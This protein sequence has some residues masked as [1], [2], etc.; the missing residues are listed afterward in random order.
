MF[1]DLEV[2]SLIEVVS[3]NRWHP[4]EIFRQVAGRIRRYRYEGMAAG[5]RVFLHFGNRLEFFADLLAIWKLGAVAIPVDGR[6]TAFEVL[7]LAR[8]ADPR[9]SIIDEKTDPSTIEGV[10][11]GSVRV[12]NTLDV[13]TD[14]GAVPDSNFVESPA[15][16]EDDALILFTSGSTGTPKGVVHTHGSLR[17]RWLALRESLG[18][19]SYRRTLCL[20]PTHFGH[21]LICNCLFP[22]LF[23][24]DLFIA[25]PYHPELIMRLGSLIDE[26]KIT[27]L[28]SVPSLWQLALKTSRS[29]KAQTLERVHCG[30]APLSAHLWQE[31]QSWAS[32]KAVFNAYG[33]TETASWVAGT[34]LAD[35]TPM[36]GLVGKPW[37]AVIKILKTC[38]TSTL[39]D[40]GMECAPGKSGYV[41]INTPALM[42]GY[43]NQ[44]HL[45]GQVIRKGWFLTGDIGVFDE[46]GVFF[47]KGREREEI[48]KSGIKIYPADIDA[49][50]EQFE[51]TVDVCTFGFDDQLCGQNVGMAVVLK[52][53]ETTTIRE[54]YWWM[55]SHLAEFK[56][57]VRWYLMDSI[58]RS[59]RGKTNRSAVMKQCAG[60]PPVDLQNV[61]RDLRE[62]PL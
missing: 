36:D 7:T 37:G 62:R 39:W 53:T 41:W 35:F 42:R 1:F 18:L 52:D 8:A 38:D 47:L 61:V 59:S 32:T 24:Q 3:G 44:D 31:I 13:E 43:L 40:P 30:S 54:L 17:A 2:G 50:A 51:R 25:P 48:N 4:G 34:T 55:K 16:L 33:I 49:V 6:L 19:S 56:I 11:S 58:P 29:P 28:S 12:M 57:P 14:A 20:L 10:S 27:F 9:F 22:W 21:G 46:H 26:H 60:L 15:K 45:T 23:G 5:D